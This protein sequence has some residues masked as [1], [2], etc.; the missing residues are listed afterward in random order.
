[1]PNSEALDEEQAHRL[2]HHP[3]GPGFIFKVFSSRWVTFSTAEEPY[4]PHLLV[5]G[6]HIASYPANLQSTPLSATQGTRSLG[7]PEGL[8]ALLMHLRDF[9]VVNKLMMIFVHRI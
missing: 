9:H 6:R 3:G 7:S 8:S 4:L 2:N 5:H 1:L